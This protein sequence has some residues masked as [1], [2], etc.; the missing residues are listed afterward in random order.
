[1]GAGIE[2]MDGMHD[3]HM[4]D[5]AMG[6]VECREMMEHYQSARWYTDNTRSHRCPGTQLWVWL[7]RKWAVFLERS[8]HLTPREGSGSLSM[9]LVSYTPWCLGH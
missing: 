2:V 1:M 6:L 7:R 9:Q 4:Q 3:M 5:K 8:Q